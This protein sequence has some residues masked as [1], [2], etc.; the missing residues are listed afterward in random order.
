MLPLVTANMWFTRS[1]MYIPAL[2]S[3]SHDSSRQSNAVWGG[4]ATVCRRLCPSVLVRGHLSLLSRVLATWELCGMLLSPK[5]PLWGLLHGSAHR[6]DAVS[7]P[8]LFSSTQR[9]LQPGPQAN[10]RPVACYPEGLQGR[11]DWQSSLILSTH[12]CLSSL[13]SLEGQHAQIHTH[14][15]GKKL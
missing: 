3:L 15:K 14:R 1:E 6:R 9:V 4:Q 11:K 5:R 13:S 7:L 2:S 12:P 10:F 8:H